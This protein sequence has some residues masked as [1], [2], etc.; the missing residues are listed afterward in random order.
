[1]SINRW[2]CL[3]SN[4]GSEFLFLFNFLYSLVLFLY[5]IYPS[6]LLSFSLLLPF[7]C[8]S[9]SC[10][11]HLRHTFTAPSSPPPAL[12]FR[13]LSLSPSLPVKKPNTI[14]TISS[15]LNLAFLN[16]RHHKFEAF[17]TTT[18]I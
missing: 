12:V 2:I 1:M 14:P 3:I 9:P 5:Q 15:A 16:P 4:S 18:C 6:A 17:W 11:L 10:L 8:P 13:S 7:L